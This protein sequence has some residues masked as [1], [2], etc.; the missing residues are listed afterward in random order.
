MPVCFCLQEFAIVTGLRCHRPEGPPRKRSKARKSKEKIDGL[1]DTARRGYKAL[2]LLTDLEDKTIPEQYR[3]QLCLV[4]FSHSV[5]LVRDVN[6]VIKDDLLARAKDFDKFNN[7][8][9]GYD[10][11]HLTVQYL[12]TKLSSG[13]TTLYGFPW[14]FMPFEAIPFLRKQL[15]DYPDEVSHP[16]MF[17]WLAEKSNTNIKEAG[18]FNPQDYAMLFLMHQMGTS[19]VHPWIV[20]TGEESVMTSYITLGHVDIIADPTVELIKKEL[21]RATVIR[22]AVRQGQP[23]IKALHDQATKADPGAFFGGVVGIGECKAKQDKLFEK[24]EVI[25]KA[26]EKFKSKRCFIPS[27][28]VREPHT[29]TVLARRNKR[30]IRDVLSGQK[31][32]EIAI[33]PSPKVVEVQR[34]VKKVYIYTELGA[35]E[36]KDLR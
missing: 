26:I 28:R 8:P 27:K 20:P 25:S 13:T 24:L 12:L 1:F 11:F 4:W 31:S 5:I 32:K 14:A 21:D 34:T 16:R 15:M 23:N 36:K 33:P 18:P 22:R 3:E 6:K 35:E 2:D 7:H 30:E 29:P 19:V 10:N 17:R 9:W